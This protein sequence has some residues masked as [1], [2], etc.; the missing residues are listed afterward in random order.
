MKYLYLTHE[1]LISK[2]NKKIE[3]EN[4]QFQVKEIE[5]FE[6][7]PVVQSIHRNFKNIV[8][9]R[10]LAIEIF[11]ENTFWGLSYPSECRVGLSS[12]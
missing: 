10:L 12:T 2:K 8:S 6:F 5:Y 3:R 7:D 4:I 9:Q 1:N 11:I